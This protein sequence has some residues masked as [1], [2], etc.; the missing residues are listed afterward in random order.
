MTGGTIEDLND[1]D[2]PVPAERFQIPL[3][4][5]YVLDTHAKPM[6]QHSTWR[7]PQKQTNEVDIV[8]LR[9]HLFS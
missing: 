1:V 6:S 7:G 4:T 8:L 2:L 3:P 9:G 5:F